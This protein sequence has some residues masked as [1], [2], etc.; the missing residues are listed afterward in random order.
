MFMYLH[1]PVH[2]SIYMYDNLNMNY[3]N[4]KSS[5]MSMTCMNII[6]YTNHEHHK[7]HEP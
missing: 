2:V 6:N 4:V 5:Y 3:I 1:V 7:L